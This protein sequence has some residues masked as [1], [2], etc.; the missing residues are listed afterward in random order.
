MVRRL[1][2]LLM[3][4]P[5]CAAAA[6]SAPAPMREGMPLVFHEDFRDGEAALARFEVDDPGSWR[7]AQVDGAPVLELFRAQ[8]PS[9]STPPVRAARNQAWWIGASVS[10]FVLEARLRSTA[11]PAGTR[12]LCV[13]FGG[14]DARHFLYAHL[15][16]KADGVH[17]HIHVVDGAP[18]VAISQ[19]RSAGT[20]WTDGWHR[21][22]VSRSA[23]GAI[24]VRFD[25]VA[26]ITAQE[27]RM[28]V[29]RIGLGSF[30]DPGQFA[31]LSVWG[32]RP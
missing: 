24:A 6:V 15:G 25:G 3:P 11:K 30:D 29:G 14:V 23:T 13:L 9:G 28:P 4:L 1:L 12:D 31:S 20:P 8:A 19:W 22:E 10:A 26:A 2:L 17:H 7:V 16:Q 27:T 5:A 18:R 21:V 32:I